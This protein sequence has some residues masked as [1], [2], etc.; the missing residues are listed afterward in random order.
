[1]RHI[2]ALKN[3]YASLAE[4]GVIGFHCFWCCGGCSSNGVANYHDA[5]PEGERAKVVGYVWYHEQ[6]AEN[7]INGYGLDLFYSDPPNGSNP[8]R[9]A[10]VGR[11]VV[12]AL[13]KAG[14]TATWNGDP[15]DVIE[16]P[17]FLVT[18]HEIPPGEGS[19][20]HEQADDDEDDDDWWDE[21]E[22]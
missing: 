1:M 6:M 2:E 3:A 5:L 19:R 11:L 20:L 9:T 22:D 13:E 10:K 7:A 16:I 12:D 21:D 4:Q 18:L 15:T 14:L 17:N 8:N